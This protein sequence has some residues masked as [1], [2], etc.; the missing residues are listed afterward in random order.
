MYPWKKIIMLILGY[1]N[2]LPRGGFPCFCDRVIII[3]I[4]LFDWKY[5]GNHTSREK[6]KSCYWGDLKEAK[7]VRNHRGTFREQQAVGWGQVQGKGSGGGGKTEGSRA[8]L[9]PLNPTPR[10]RGRRCICEEEQPG[11]SW[12]FPSW[13][14]GR[15]RVSESSSEAT[16][17]AIRVYG[18]ERKA[19][20][21]GLPWGRRNHTSQLSFLGKKHHSKI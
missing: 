6:I 16:L 10:A 1:G 11:P 21:R 17:K 18:Q 19:R 15:K 4:I 5:R 20:T 12:A 14:W 7:V 9:W 3:S 13:L 2:L 8:M